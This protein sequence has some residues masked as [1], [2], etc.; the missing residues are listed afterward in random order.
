MA[1]I[2]GINH[3]NLSVSDL[4]RSWHFYSELLGLKP[5]AKWPKGAYFLAGDQWFCINLDQSARTAPIQEYTHLAFSI[6]QSN[7]QSLVTKLLQA[8]VKIWKENSSPGDSF[9]FLDPDGHKLEIHVSDWKSRVEIAK[10]EQWEGM[11]FF[12]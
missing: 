6:D 7:F 5:L 8:G 11:Q 12:V 9:Y 10:Q 1:M 2:T 4:E 3:I